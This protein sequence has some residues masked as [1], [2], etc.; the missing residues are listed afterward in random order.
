MET[1]E[2]PTMAPAEPIGT[3]AVQ[4]AFSRLRGRLLNTEL[5]ALAAG[6]TDVSDE[7]DPWVDEQPGPEWEDQGDEDQGDDD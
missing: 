6:W 5:T 3:K 4:G 2:K 1:R 7:P